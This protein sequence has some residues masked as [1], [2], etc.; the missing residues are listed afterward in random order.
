MTV[1]FPMHYDVSAKAKLCVNQTLF[2]ADFKLTVVERGP[3]LWRVV[4]PGV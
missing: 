2:L 4:A 1:L 3:F